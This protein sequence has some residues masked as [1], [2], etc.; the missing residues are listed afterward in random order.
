[1]YVHTYIVSCIACVSK[2]TYSTHVPAIVHTQ[3][4]NAKC[5]DSL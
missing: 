2:V 5:E 3:A 1:M 4:T